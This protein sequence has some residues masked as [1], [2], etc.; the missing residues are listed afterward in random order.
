MIIGNPPWGYEF[1]EEQK[2]LLRNKYISAIGTNIESYDIF[3]EQALSNLKINGQLSF[4]LPEAFLNVKAHTSIRSLLMKNSSFQ[5]LEFLGNAFDKV[6]CPC[7][8]L[9]IFY[10]QKPFD[11]RGLTVNDGI[12]EYTISYPRNVNA[13]CFSFLTTDTEYKIID[14][15]NKMTNKI[16]LFGD[17]I[18]ALGIVTGNNKDYISQVKTQ[19]NEIIL[20]GSDI[21]RFRFNHSDN[22]I[23]FRPDSFQQTAPVQYYRAKEKLLYRFICNQLIFAYDDKQTLSLNSCNLLIPTVHNLNIKYLMA[24]LNS[25]ATQFFFKKQFHSVKVL[26]SHI[27]QI[28][29]PQIDEESQIP[30]I[31]LVDAILDSTNKYDILSIY[32]TLD[33]EIAKLYHLTEVEHNIIIKSMEGENLFL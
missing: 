14:K 23:V 8:I 30:I 12:R 25:R 7:I 26:R 4:V 22:Y 17:A 24:V 3:V 33:F 2:Q 27:E 11:S 13:E 16:F 18:F 31:T 19:D 15:M 5:Y 29:I 9:Q 6:Q 21:C 10:N 28:P 20:K 1:S 32:E